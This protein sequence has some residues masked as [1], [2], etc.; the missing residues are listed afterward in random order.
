M[1]NILYRDDDPSVY[2]CITEFKKINDY[3]IKKDWKHT[4]A[5]LMKDLWQNHALFY[6]LAT[7]PNIDVELHGWEHKDYSILSYDEC[8]EDLNK[9]INYWRSNCQRMIGNIKPLTTFFA[10]WN[11][12]GDN[13]K[14]ACEDVGLKFCNVKEGVWEDKKI[15]SFHWWSFNYDI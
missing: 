14:K 8:F 13:I 2:T 9:S 7:T 10:P 3:F 4:V 5:V 12:E 1:S 6:Y 11:R 15:I